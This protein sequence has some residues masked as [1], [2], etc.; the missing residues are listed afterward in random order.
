PCPKKVHPHLNLNKKPQP[1]NGMLQ[2]CDSHKTVS[3][4]LSCLNTRRLTLGDAE[5]RRIG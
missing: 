5:G 1:H 2:W 4:F 3:W